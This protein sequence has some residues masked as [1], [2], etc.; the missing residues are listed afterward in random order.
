MQ[1][2]HETGDLIFIL[3]Q[4]PH[5]LYTRSSDH[6]IIYHTINLNE[7]MCGFKY[8][9]KHLD[10]RYLLINHPPGEFITDKTVKCIPNKGMPLSMDNS[11]FGDLYI[12]FEINFPDNNYFSPQELEVNTKL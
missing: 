8:A 11:K 12:K 7:A 6:L 2:D 3:E 4:E 10:G 1:P 5:E 9:F